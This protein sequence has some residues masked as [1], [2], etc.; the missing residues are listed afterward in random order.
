MKKTLKSNSRMVLTK[1][2][3]D[4]L[5]IAN[6]EILEKL[7]EEQMKRQ[8]K[9]KVN[10]NRSPRNSNR[11][12]LL[13]KIRNSKREIP[14]N[15]EGKNQLF[16]KNSDPINPSN[17]N[18]YLSDCNTKRKKFHLNGTQKLELKRSNSKFLQSMTFV[19]PSKN[20][21]MLQREDSAISGDKSPPQFE[22]SPEY[23]KKK[24]LTSRKHKAFFDKKM[25][26]IKDHNAP[27]KSKLLLAIAKKSLPILRTLEDERKFHTNSKNPQLTQNNDDKT[28]LNHLKSIHEKQ[29]KNLKKTTEKIYRER[30]RREMLD[31]D[32]KSVIDFLAKGRSICEK[33]VS[34]STK[35]AIWSRRKLEEHH[36]REYS[37][38]RKSQ[39]LKKLVKKKTENFISLNSVMKEDGFGSVFLGHVELTQ[40]SMN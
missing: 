29:Y 31:I 30:K 34:E 36:M 4:F 11:S 24:T 22:K 1:N 21:K 20:T 9:I 37:Y 25:L 12:T 16:A 8:K 14:S 27:R 33:Y 23:T 35:Y 6:K 3:V 17:S 10:F 5:K 19:I 18:A 2:G 38:N 39:G 28:R 7:A 40:R 15:S 26:K 13:E 32:R